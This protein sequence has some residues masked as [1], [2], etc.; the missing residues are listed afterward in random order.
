MHI[1]SDRVGIDYSQQ[2]TLQG[3]VIAISLEE[4]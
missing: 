4:P 3:R 2:V 1:E